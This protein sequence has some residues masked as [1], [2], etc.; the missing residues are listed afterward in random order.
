MKTAF[1]K[2][3]SLMLTVMVILGGVSFTPASVFAADED[4]SV[5][6]SVTNNMGT[7]FKE[8]IEYSNSLTSKGTKANK[9]KGSSIKVRQ[10]KMEKGSDNKDTSGMLEVLKADGNTITFFPKKIRL[11]KTRDMDRAIGYVFD[12]IT[13]DGVV[14]NAEL[15][16]FN[17]QLSAA[18]DPT[19]TKMI[20]PIIM[21]RMTPDL[22][23]AAKWLGPFLEIMKVVVGIAVILIIFFVIASTV[24]DLAYIGVPVFRETLISKSEG[25]EGD[26]PKFIT[27]E[28]K[29][30]VMEVEKDLTK[31]YKN[32]YGMYF[33]RRAISYIVLAICLMYLV[34]GGLGGIVSWIMNLASGVT[35]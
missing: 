20:L 11:A 24:L 22:W 34:V 9:D 33:K 17:T 2:I 28:A 6:I 15:Q 21:A 5:K 14:D 4:D 18:N 1:Q 23:T 3:M 19:I 25:K 16:E 32:A 27:A 13:E 26:G 30:T 7:A 35:G 10:A 8:A 29:S 12:Y 31:G